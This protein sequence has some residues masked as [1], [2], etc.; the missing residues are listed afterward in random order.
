MIVDQH[1]DLYSFFPRFDKYLFQ[2]KSFCSITPKYVTWFFG[3]ILWLLCWKL[4]YLL[5]V[6][7]LGFN[8][9]ISVFLA[10]KESLF[11]HTH[12]TISF[13]SLL[14]FLFNFLSYFSTAR[15][16]ASSANWWTE[17][18]WT[19]RWRSLMNKIKSRWP[20]TDPCCTPYFN[21]FMLDL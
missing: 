8:I 16:F 17:P 12:S 4:R 21:Y 11:A 14:T 20:K 9:I 15:R 18:Y 7:F 3:L 5:I 2:C 13:R 10:F 19:A 6:L 1:Y